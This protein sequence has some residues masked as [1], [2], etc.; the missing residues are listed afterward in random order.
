MLVCLLAYLAGAAEGAAGARRASFSVTLKATVT[1]EWNT[2]GKTTSMGCPVSKRSVGRRT[3]KLRSTRPTTVVATFAD[4]RVSYAPAAVRFVAVE[5]S[6]SGDL[7]TGFQAPCRVRNVKSRCRRARRAVGGATYGYFRSQRNEISF[8]NTRLP[9]SGS[10]CPREP[11]AVRAI[12]PGLHEAQ[13]GLS[14]ATLMN[15]RYPSQT[16][17]GTAVTETDLEGTEE[18]RVVERVSWSL[19]F[20]RKG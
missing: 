14:E 2:V 13:G 19:T 9:Q 16:A 3:V 12:R 11:S 15:A 8:R 6:Q 1:K 20:T 5:V 17:L 7:T 4:G 18:G 10:S